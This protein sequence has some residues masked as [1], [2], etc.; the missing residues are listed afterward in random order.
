MRQPLQDRAFRGTPGQAQVFATC[1]NAFF[2]P[3]SVSRVAVECEHSVAEYL[4]GE[5]RRGVAQIRK[6][7]R[8]LEPLGKEA[9]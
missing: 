6:V 1:R 4:K 8:A 5:I 3:N 2:E 7:D 9:G